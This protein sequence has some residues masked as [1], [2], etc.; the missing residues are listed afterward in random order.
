MSLLH[1]HSGEVAPTACRQIAP[2]LD[3]AAAGT[4]NALTNWYANA[5]ADR[6]ECCSDYRKRTQEVLP[7]K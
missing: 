7:A 4:G 5:H 3:K 6:C 1:P 2:L